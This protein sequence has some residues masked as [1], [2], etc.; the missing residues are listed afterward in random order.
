MNL[1]VVDESLRRA[2]LAAAVGLGQSPWRFSCRRRAIRFLIRSPFFGRLLDEPKRAK[3]RHLYRSRGSRL[4]HL[5]HGPLFLSFDSCGLL[6]GARFYFYHFFQYPL[7]WKRLAALKGTFRRPRIQSRLLCRAP[8]GFASIIV[9][10]D[11]IVS[12]P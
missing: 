10:E 2:V 4:L 8:C 7:V 5:V 3:P 1:V 9:F 12:R 11:R 6:L